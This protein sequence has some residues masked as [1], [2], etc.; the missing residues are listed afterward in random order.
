MANIDLSNLSVAQLKEL[1]LKIE[2]EV[3]SKRQEELL[4][5]KAD[6][7]AT[8]EK[9]GFNLDEVMSARNARTVKPKY[10]NPQNADETWSGR[11]RKPRWVVALIEAGTDIESCAI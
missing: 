9:Y 1:E 7:E 6:I 4:M 5:A 11:G 3:Q 2:K 10:Q 8:L